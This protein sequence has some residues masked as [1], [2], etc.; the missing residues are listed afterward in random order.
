MYWNFGF[1]ITIS[2]LVI[3]NQ[4]SSYNALNIEQQARRGRG[5]YIASNSE[6]K[7]D[8]SSFSSYQTSTQGKYI[9]DHNKWAY[10]PDNR[11]KYVHVHI[12]Y[13]G[14]YGPFKNPYEHDG[15][16]YVHDDKKYNDPFNVEVFTDKTPSIYREYGAPLFSSN[17]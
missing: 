17:F 5:K 1:F 15:R 14:G 2:I 7:L 12:P 3:L 11:G 16:D 13:N 4:F 9:A 6:R 10:K 8:S